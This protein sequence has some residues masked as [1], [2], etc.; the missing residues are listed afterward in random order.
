MGQDSQP[1]WGSSVTTRVVVRRKLRAA[2][3]HV[4]SRSRWARPTADR[5]VSLSSVAP[6][7]IM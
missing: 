7:N 5:Q 4:L 3:A 2:A 1:V 6:C